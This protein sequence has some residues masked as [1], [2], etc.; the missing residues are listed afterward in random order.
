MKYL[1]V[2]NNAKRYRGVFSMGAIGALSP[3]ILKNR[4]LAPEIFGHS[5]TVGKN[6]AC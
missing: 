5:S 4:L 1:L 3:A 6:C 2:Q